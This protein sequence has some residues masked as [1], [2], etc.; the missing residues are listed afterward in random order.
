MADEQWRNRPDATD[1]IGPKFAR[2]VR[3]VEQQYS[4]RWPIRGLANTRTREWRPYEDVS[5]EG[6]EVE[7]KK[8]PNAKG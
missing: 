4:D 2:A 6:V 3:I 1:P 5:R 8:R 7:Y